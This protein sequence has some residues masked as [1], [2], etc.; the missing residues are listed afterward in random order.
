MPK[1]ILVLHSGGMD[2]TTCLYKAKFEGAEVHSV[3][4][5]YGQRLS[6][7]MLFAA[8]QCKKLKIHREVISVS[9]RKPERDIPVGRQVEEMSKS[10]SPA[11]LPGRNVLLLSLAV[12]HASG[13]GADEIHTGLNCVDFSGYPDC[14]E[15]FF[16]AYCVM[17]NV[18]IPDGPKIVAPLLKL[19]KPDIAKMAKELGIG[20]CDTWSCYRPQITGGGLTPCHE[21]DACRLHDF[22]WREIA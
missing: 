6:V 14:T 16:E 18:A 11:F 17:M 2:S 1:R 8:E 12:A 10:V 4:V 5:D 22:A 19:S 21:C 3:G 13:I 9:W 7:E 20:E 15:E